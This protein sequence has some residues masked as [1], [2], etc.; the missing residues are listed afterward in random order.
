M[1]QED[2]RRQP[3]TSS[4]WRWYFSPTAKLGQAQTSLASPGV[5][6][7]PSL[8]TFWDI[9]KQ[10][11]A[12]E[13]MRGDTYVPKNSFPSMTGGEMGQCA[14]WWMAFTQVMCSVQ[15]DTEPHQKYATVPSS[16]WSINLLSATPAT[17]KLSMLKSNI[18]HSRQFQ[19]QRLLDKLATPGISWFECRVLSILSNYWPVRW[20]RAI[21]VQL[22]QHCGVRKYSP[23]TVTQPFRLHNKQHQLQSVSYG[24]VQKTS[25]SRFWNV[26]GSQFCEAHLFILEHQLYIV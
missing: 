17:F 2:S 22:P 19:Q 16:C 14:L 12:Y 5:E 6:N 13:L 25:P 7:H 9:H 10:T 24:K 20:P 8:H 1:S 26:N 11:Q 4:L 15:R 18:S 21:I 3:I 23:P